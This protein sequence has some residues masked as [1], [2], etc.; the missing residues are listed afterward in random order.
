[1]KDSHNLFVTY[2]PC[3][4]NLKFKIAD[5]SL[6]SVLGKGSIQISNSITLEH[7]FHVPNFSNNLLS[8]SQLTKSSNYCANFFPLNV[9]FRTY[10]RG[11][12][13]AMLKNIEDSTTLMRLMWV[14]IYVNLLVVILHLS[15]RIVKC[16][17]G[18]I[19]WVTPTFSIYNM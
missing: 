16:F 3:A 2:S 12:W 8:V 11:K 9:S 5:D 1:M 10:H 14:V 19:E 15:L 18:I 7:A 17:Y 6:S 13:L 4:G